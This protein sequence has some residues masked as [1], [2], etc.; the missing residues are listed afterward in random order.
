M[1]TI[2]LDLH[3]FGV[4]CIA[5]KQLEENRIT[6]ECF[7]GFMYLVASEKQEPFVY[8]YPLNWF[9]HLK[10][11]VKLKFPR[12]FKFKI[13]YK[14]EEVSIRTIYPFLKTR[15]PRA[16][17]GQMVRVLVNDNVPMS[18]WTKDDTFPV[19]CERSTPQKR[20]F[21]EDP[22]CPYCGYRKEVEST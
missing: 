7:S 19:L 8:R 12:L 3:A 15:L 16:V 20:N 9:E 13:K 11:M 2:E 1:K 18:F 4:E 21:Y 17:M 5:T 22:L 6:G 10:E 14:V